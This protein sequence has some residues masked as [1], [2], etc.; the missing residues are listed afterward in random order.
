M[1]S[2][3]GAIAERYLTLISLSGVIAGL[4][5]VERVRAAVPEAS[6]ADLMQLACAE[7]VEV[8]IHAG[9]LLERLLEH[10]SECNT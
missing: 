3:F 2:A 4:A 8:I 7:A 6:F 10:S 9:G 1:W 5:L